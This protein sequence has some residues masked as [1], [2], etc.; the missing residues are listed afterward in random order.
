MQNRLSEGTTSSLL[1]KSDQL[2]SFVFNVLASATIRIWDNDAAPTGALSG[3]DEDED[4]EAD[5]DDEAEDSE[6]IGPD[7]ELIE[8]AITLLLSILEGILCITFLD[9]MLIFVLADDGLSARTQ[10]ILNDIFSKLEPLALKGSSVLRPLA[11]EARLVITARL[12]NSSTNKGAKHGSAEEEDPQEIYQ[13]ALKL[14]QDPILPVRAHGLL[15]LRQL[16]SSPSAK[17]RQAEKALMPSIL[18]IF[19]QCVH[20]DDSYMFLNAVQGL[21]AFVG[22]YGKEILR[23]LVNDY[24]GGLEG[25]GAGNLNQQD[26]DVRTR[27]GEALGSVIKQCGNTLGLYGTIVLNWNPYSTC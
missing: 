24:A 21:A 19:L 25:L 16:A 22:S 20:D 7:D 14:L 27:I 1:R 2:L 9:C 4:E 11:R 18:S 17:H 12:A 10:P 23:R 13:K 5:S 6:V 8:T 26:I 15:L 3:R